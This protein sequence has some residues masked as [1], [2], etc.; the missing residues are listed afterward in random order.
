L[1]SGELDLQD[2]PESSADEE[3]GS[4]NNYGTV[5]PEDDFTSDN[6]KAAAALRKDPT[7][8]MP[9]APR[10]NPCLWLFHFLEGIAVLTALCLLATQVMPIAITILT[11]IEIGIDV[12]SLFLKA[13]ISLFCLVFIVVETGLPVPFVKDSTLLQSYF[14]RGFIYSFLGLI[15]VE[16]AYSERVKDIVSHGKDEFHVGWAAI[17]MQISSWFM[18]GLGIVYMLLGL[19]CLQSLR[20]RMH[21]KEQEDWKEYREDLKV[22]KENNAG[23]KA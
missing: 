17:F 8:V 15:C 11:K 18:L 23:H 6:E 1:G 7:V 20:D 21:K 16:E 2:K 10:Q 19:F 13:Y 22:W 5:P 14:S 12:L 3:E 4:Q 9:Y